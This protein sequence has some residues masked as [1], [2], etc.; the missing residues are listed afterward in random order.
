MEAKVHRAGDYTPQIFGSR[1]VEGDKPRLHVSFQR[2]EGVE[3]ACWQRT[4]VEGTSLPST[5]AQGYGLCFLYE[6]DAEC[7]VRRQWMR[8][9]PGAYLINPNDFIRVGRR[10]TYRTRAD[11]F[12][13]DSE[14]FRNLLREELGVARDVSFSVYRCD[15]A[16]LRKMLVRCFRL[17]A[18]G[19]SLLT[20]QCE[21]LSLLFTAVERFTEEA[22]RPSSAEC[23]IDRA[24]ALLE[25]SLEQ[26]IS[27]DTLAS[28][29]NVSRFKLIRQFKSEYGV[30]PHRFHIHVRIRRAK[31][32]L[33]QQRS[34]VDTALACGFSDQSH[35]TRHFK[36]IVGVTPGRFVESLGLSVAA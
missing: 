12:W 9:P 36:Q 19:A 5:L 26:N 25:G 24:V 22:P 28:L 17:A 2:I 14:A 32:M 30:P 20:L 33:L 31:Q 11:V 35:L 18:E 4:C 10:F 21:L 6:G 23:S 8:T 34:L 13:F 29:C 3:G 15:D 1:A 27:L 16:V 7:F